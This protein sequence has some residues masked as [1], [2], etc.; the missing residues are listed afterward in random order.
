MYQTLLAFIALMVVML[1]TI[2][3][4]RA[5]MQLNAGRSDQEVQSLAVSAGQDVLDF[6]GA[7]PF[8]AATILG[9]VTDASEL[10]ASPF[11]SGGDYETAQDIDDFH[12][13]DPY[14]YVSEVEDISYTLNIEVHYVED[15]DPSTQSSVQTFS[16]EVVITLSNPDMLNDIQLSR[17]Y[18]YP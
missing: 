13:I 1:L 12:Q 11:A 18:T 14:T 5:L 4:Q 6:I 15:D 7:K 10:T 8:D 2:N 9:T 16:K 3:Q 17:V